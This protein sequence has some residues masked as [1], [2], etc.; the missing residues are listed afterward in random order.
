MSRS[1]A[2]SATRRPARTR[3]TARARNS[4]RYG[5]GTIE[6]FSESLIS[7]ARVETI[8][9]GTSR[10]HHNLQQSLPALLPGRVGRRHGT[11]RGEP[12]PR[13]ERAGYAV[14]TRGLGAARRLF[15]LLDAAS[16]FWPR[17]GFRRRRRGL[18]GHVQPRV[19]SGL[20]SPLVMTTLG[21]GLGGAAGG[22]GA[23]FSVIVPL[24]K[25]L[26]DHARR[27]RDERKSEEHEPNPSAR[28]PEV[29]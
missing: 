25:C 11:V 17:W 4:A 18:A 2:T 7:T 19:S 15:A 27:D 23:D 14:A 1:Y 29:E 3:A 28:R 20:P 16:G 24:S 22:F 12:C 21:S 6:A 10:S 9:S 26:F 13:P 8:P 5:F